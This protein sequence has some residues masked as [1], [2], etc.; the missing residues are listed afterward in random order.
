MSDRQCPEGVIV[1]GVV[2]QCG[3]DGGHEGNHVGVYDRGF[4]EWPRIAVDPVAEWKAAHRDHP[5]QG[6]PF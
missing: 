1:D 6:V 5:D 2:T 4:A 3:R